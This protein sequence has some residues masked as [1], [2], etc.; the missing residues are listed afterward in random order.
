MTGPTSNRV[1][2]QKYRV[3]NQA[4]SVDT[5]ATQGAQFGVN[6]WD[7]SGNLVAWPLATSTPST[8][9]SNFDGTTDDVDEGQFN[10][11]FTN[12]RAQNAVGGILQNTGSILLTYSGAPTA[13][14]ISAQADLFYLMATR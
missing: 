10:L 9:E 1:Q 7:P 13:P 4:V 12:L 14:K 8:G 11:Y 2:V 6:I 3:S 5:N